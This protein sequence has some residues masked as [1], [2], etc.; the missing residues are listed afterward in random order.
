M[1]QTTRPGAFLVIEEPGAIS[2]DNGWLAEGENLQ[3]GTLLAENDDGDLVAWESGACAGI[4]FAGTDARS[5]RQ[6]VAIISRLAVVNF[7]LLD[8]GTAEESDA[9]DALQAIRI[10]VLAD[11]PIPSAATGGGGGGG[12]DIIVDFA[13]G[14]YSVNGASVPLSDV[15]G[16]DPNWGT[17]SAGQITAG[18]GIGNGVTPSALGSFLSAILAQCTCVVS[19]TFALP[20]DGSSR[21]ILEAYEP[22][23]SAFDTRAE[24]NAI[25]DFISGA[26]VNLAAAPAA[27][28]HK[29]AFTILDGSWSGS[30]DGGTVGTCAIAESLSLATGLGIEVDGVGNFLTKIEVYTTPKLNSDLPALS[31]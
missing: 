19:A 22:S 17:F 4:L 8:Y 12:A 15:I 14:V 5:A 2:R 9:R 28:S 6:Q 26:F 27:G 25:S 21:I 1:R 20:V 29:L 23:Y 13:N 16:E 3:A 31:A 7:E 10:E 18:S 24:I 30:M 11:H